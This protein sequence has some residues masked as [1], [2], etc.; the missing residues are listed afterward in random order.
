MFALRGFDKGH[1]FGF[2]RPGAAVH[3]PRLQLEAR[4][5]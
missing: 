4:R 3:A 2:E 5:C 1:K